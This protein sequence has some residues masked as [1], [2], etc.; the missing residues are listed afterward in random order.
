MSIRSILLLLFFSVMF[1]P[2]TVTAQSPGEEQPNDASL[3]SFN[4]EPGQRAA[5]KDVLHIDAVEI[6][7]TAVAQRSALILAVKEAEFLF[8][9]ANKS[10]T[11]GNTA[12]AQDLYDQS[13]RKLSQANLDAAVLN[14]LRDDF[15]SLFAKLNNSLN[16]GNRT[17]FFKRTYNIPMDA[18]NETVKKYLKRY[19]ENGES[20][21][22]IKAALERSGRYRPMILTTLKEYDLPKELIYLP[23]VESLYR[24][25]DLSRAGALGLWQIM[26]QRA[27]ALDLKLNYWID[28]RK[29]PE[30]STRAAARYLKELFLMLDDWHLVLAGYNRGEFGLV[31]DLKF[32]NATTICEMAERSAVPKETQLYVPQFIAVSMIGEDPQK[33]GYD[34]V[35][36]PPLVY[37]T[38]KIPTVIDLKIVAQC[39]G[40]SLSTIRELNPSLIAWCTPHNAPDFELHIPS[41]T[42]GAFTANIALVKD[43]NPSPG[44]IKY[45]VLGNDWLE[46]IAK[47]FSTTVTAIKED[48]ARVKKQKYLRVGQVL[49]IRPG[50]KYKG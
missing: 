20:K 24:V 46:K 33:Y 48:N 50:R 12:K 49:I 38:V 41:G 36:D 43:L 37:D 9:Q 16:V 30:K 40:T 7:T 25:E 4:D 28:E 42:A 1:I 22:L 14:A 8:N 47:K 26:P 5:D 29:D 35:Y 45:K 11:K 3:Q 39:A 21:R 6:S 2:M 44:Y 23:V 17:T 18:D 31:R 15:K 32:S 13:L 19:T 27:R 10:F 34:L